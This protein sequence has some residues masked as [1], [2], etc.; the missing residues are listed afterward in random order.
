MIGP[1]TSY[2]AQAK[3]QTPRET[4]EFADMRHELERVKIQSLTTGDHYAIICLSCEPSANRSMKKVVEQINRFRESVAEGWAHETIVGWL[5][6]QTLAVILPNASP[7]DAWEYCEKLRSICGTDE[8]S[9]FAKDATRI[10][11]G[12]TEIAISSIDDF[13]LRPSSRWKRLFDLVVGGSMLMMALPFILLAALLVRLTTSGPAF[14]SQKRVGFGGKPFSIYKLRTMREDADDRKDEFRQLNEVDGL[15]FKIEKD[16][17]V[18]EVG[19]FLRK[20]SIDEL[21]Q[22]W[23]VIRGEMSLVGPRPLPCN[24]WHPHELWMNAR[25]DVK[26][27]L[28]CIWQ[29]KGRGDRSS[30]SFEEWM[31]M[32]IEYIESSDWQTDLKLMAQ[33]IPAVLSQRGA[34]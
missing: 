14:F 22:L 16:P 25:H 24:D 12:G 32:D 5:S 2:P 4:R 23:N 15:G 31:K 26:P 28:T 17:R 7:V 33:T 29:I 19:R 21:P 30:V 9:V 27:G 1:I 20:T 11:L 3:D 10:T 6:M 34:T 8:I 18:T 13:L